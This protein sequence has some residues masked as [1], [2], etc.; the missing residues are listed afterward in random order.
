MGFRDLPELGRHYASQAGRLV[1][2]FYIPVLSQA[3]RYDRQAGYFDSATLVQLASGLVAFIHHARDLLPSDPP[4]MRLITGATWSP[5][6]LV[7]YQ[8]GVD[9]LQESLNLTLLGHFEPS[10]EEC[11]RLGLPPGW[12]PEEDQIARYRFGALAWMVAAGLLDVRI[13]LPLD[14]SGRPYQPGR[15]GALY[16]PKAGILYDQDG[17]TVFFRAR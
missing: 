4:P 12:R 3:V 11:I 7:A 14:P 16:H 17:N 2:E 6:D 15:H 10:A 1:N 13:A 8:R 5:E 9:L